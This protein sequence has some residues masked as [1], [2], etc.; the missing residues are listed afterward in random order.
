VSTPL[1]AF[2]EDVKHVDSFRKL[3]HVEDSILPLDMEPDLCDTGADRRHRPPVVRLQA[4]LKSAELTTG[5]LP[6]RLGEATKV[7]EGAAGPEDRLVGYR[8]YISTCI[9]MKE[10]IRMDSCIGDRR[11]P[12]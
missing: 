3:G 2:L 6:R 11:E 8:Q 4:L 10:P 9:V 1:S 7:L 5:L 12:W